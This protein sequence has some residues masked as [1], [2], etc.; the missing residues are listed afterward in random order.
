MLF[1]YSTF[2][3]CV[4]AGW[5]LSIGDQTIAGWGIS[6]GYALAAVLAVIVLCKAPFAPVH[7]G[8]EQLL[9]LLI[10]G[11]MAAIAI[12]KQLDLQTLVLT[13]G[14]CL[15]KEQ[16]WYESRRLVQR[17][18]IFLLMGIAGLIGVAIIWLLRGIVRHNWVALIGLSVLAIFIVI[19]A[20]HLFHIFMPEHQLADK[21]VHLFTTS[22]EALSPILIIGAAAVLLRNRGAEEQI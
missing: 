11:L 7:N 3:T 10:A 4:S 9:W 22:L 13:A 5:Q 19:R 21:L 15:A 1:S 8:R 2:S 6:A 12:N 16:G 17:D 14:R 18:F 20:G